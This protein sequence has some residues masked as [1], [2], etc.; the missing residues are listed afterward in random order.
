MIRPRGSNVATNEQTAANH[1][2]A[3]ASTGPRTLNGKAQ[4]TKNAQT[5]GFAS[6]VETLS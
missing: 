1:R 2:N 6:S 3:L 5:H 4:A